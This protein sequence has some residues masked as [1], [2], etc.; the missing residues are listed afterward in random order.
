MAKDIKDRGNYDFVYVVLVE[1]CGPQ[2]EI[3]Y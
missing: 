2:V 3:F 1:Y